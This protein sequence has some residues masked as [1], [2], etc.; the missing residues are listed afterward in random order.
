MAT[1]DQMT[2]PALRELLAS[3]TLAGEWILD[4]SRS[5]VALKSKS[6]GGLVT[7]NGAFRQVSGYGVVSPGGEVTGSH[8]R[9]GIDRH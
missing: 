3:A 1:S 5:T 8:R 4:P 7:V 2:G 9:R 6:I